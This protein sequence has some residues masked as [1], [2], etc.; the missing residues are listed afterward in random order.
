M[1]SSL[2]D[3]TVS[4]L[5]SHPRREA[6]LRYVFAGFVAARARASG[7]SSRFGTSSPA[8]TRTGPLSSMSSQRPA[9]SV[10]GIPA[11]GTHPAARPGSAA[12]IAMVTAM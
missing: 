5:H 4:G 6:F 9:A 8:Q 12:G 1:R 11:T 3:S 10:A 2:T 7:P